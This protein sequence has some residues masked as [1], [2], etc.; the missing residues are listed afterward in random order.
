MLRG[1]T[2]EQRHRLALRFV[3]TLDVTVE[4]LARF[5]NSAADDRG[6]S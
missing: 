2:L 3:E 1:G 4:S 6:H 5:I